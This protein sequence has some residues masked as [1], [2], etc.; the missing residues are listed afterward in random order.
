MEEIDY[1]K[2]PLENLVT[3]LRSTRRRE[4][5]DCAHELVSRCSQNPEVALEHI[6]PLQKALTC[7]E[8]QTRWEVLNAL[9]VLAPY[10]VKAVGK[11]FRDAETCLFDDESASVRLAACRFLVAY[12]SQTEKNSDKSWAVLDEFIQCYHGDPEYRD[13]L[14]M[15]LTFAQAHISRKTR[16][17]MKKRFEFDAHNSDGYI[18]K[19]SVEIIEELK[20]EE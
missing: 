19:F 18:N 12:G 8:A 20:K 4:R 3:G 2:I 9:A 14:K 11:S 1:T 5:Q 16:T 17:A 6:R 7:T 15:M 13:I 10:D